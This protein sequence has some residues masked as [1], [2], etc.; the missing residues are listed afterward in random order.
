MPNFSFF[1]DL[2]CH[3]Q[4]KPFGCATKVVNQAEVLPSSSVKDKTSIWQYDP[5]NMVDKTLNKL[6][7]I[8]R[9]RQA[10][11]TAAGYSKLWVM[12]V[13]LGSVE[14]GF[15]LNK[16]DKKIPM[17]SDCID[18]FP[19]GFGKA[20]IQTIEQM[21][22]YYPDLLNEI[23]FLEAENNVVKKID[24]QYYRYVITQSFEEMLKH[25]DDNQKQGAGTK[26]DHPFTISIILS[27][28]GLHAL[29]T[30]LKDEPVE[31]VI[32][33]R[34]IQ[35][36]HHPCAPFFV[37]FAHHFYNHLTGHARSLRKQIGQLTNQE[38]KINGPIE[39]FGFQVLDLLLDKSQ[40]K[41]ILIDIKHMSAI[42]RRQFI[43]WRSERVAG[44]DE[45]PIIISHGVANGMP[46]IEYSL[47]FDLKMYEQLK[48]KDKAIPVQRMISNNPDLGNCF[49]EK[50]EWVKGGDDKW[51]DHNLINFFDD[52]ILEMARSGGIMGLQLDE[53][54]LANHETLEKVKEA[55]RGNEKKHYRSRLLWNQIQYIGELL[56][57]NGEY[58]WG[59]LAIGSDYDGMVDPLNYFWTVDDYDELLSYLE[60]H[61]HNYFTNNG[62]RLTQD[63]NR[64]AS[65][66][67]MELIF[68][69][70]AFLFIERWM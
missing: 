13:S 67:L 61:A 6:L 63:R 39:P 4:Y 25:I 18:N 8:T 29:G 38:H 9:F 57:K 31:A 5:P 27:I 23:K 54:R 40:G 56:D 28:E 2:H 43:N 15:F 20:R 45:F 1:I 68:S 26:S 47:G 19:S 14:Q 49:I 24:G 48:I 59:N 21:T 35:L 52:E 51:K 7:G 36:K 64:I 10:N 58:A 17:F 3:P 69:K 66:V 53:R 55:E 12:V 32:K 34:L 44:G 42:A 22:D 62:S 33:E 50:I 11:L 70:N 16:L 37:T 46:S 30:G 65:S 41:R 60:R